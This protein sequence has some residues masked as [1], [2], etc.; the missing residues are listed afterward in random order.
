MELFS[1]IADER[2]KLADTLDGLTASQWQV[3]SLC[4]EWT[5]H[6]VAAHLLMP[7]VTSTP[8]V[9]AV[10][11]RHRMNW[12]KANVS[13]TARVASRSNAEIIS[14][15]RE[16]SGSHFTPPGLDAQAPLTDVI[17]HGQDIRRPL[18]IVRAI[19]EDRQ[20]V[21]LEYLTGAQA[22][23]GF[24]PKD[25]VANLKLKANDLDWT[26]GQGDLVEGPAEALMMALAGRD[27]ACADLSGDGANLLAERLATR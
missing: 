23:R 18:G 26:F 24:V 6:D 21:I 4:D 27:V 9:V 3:Q 10:M 20:L 11:V 12:D 13:L 19:P 25:R 15:L 14:G 2:E 17:V 16:Q 5:V 1:E 22:S 8:R 7:L